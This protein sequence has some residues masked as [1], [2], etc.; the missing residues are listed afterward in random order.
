VVELSDEGSYDEQVA[1]PRKVGGL[2]LPEMTAV[3][4]RGFDSARH[5]NSPRNPDSPSQEKAVGVSVIPSG[6]LAP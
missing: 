5:T 2:G 6:I 3:M 4:G 1:Y